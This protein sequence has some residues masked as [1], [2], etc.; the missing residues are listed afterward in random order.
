MNYTLKNN[1]KK[2]AGLII[3][4]GWGIGAKDDSDGVF[5]AKTPFFDNLINQY[6]NA[7]LTTFG[8]EVGLPDGQMG[9][10]EVGHLNI[11]A[12]RIVYQDLLRINNAIEDGSFFKNPQLLKAIRTAT[13]N[14]S[15]I[16]L[17]G[18]V[19]EGGV[20]SSLNHLLSLCS[21]L[22][23]NFSGRV[24]IHGFSDGRDCGPT[25]GIE[26][27]EKLHHHIHNS[28][29]VLS[30]IIG[31]YYAMDRDQRWERIKK[32]YDLLIEGTGEI[33][34]DYSTAF[35]ESYSKEITDEFLEPVKIKDNNGT[36]LDNDLVVCFNFRTDRC[37]QIT[38]AL[39]QSNFSEHGMKIK[40]LHFYTMT[41]YDKTFK[42]IEVIYDKD[43]LPMTLGEVLSNNNKK[44]L[45]IAETEKYPHVTYFFSGGREQVF[46]GESR[47]VVSS[48][49]VATYDLQPE[50]SAEKVASSTV[51]FLEEKRPDFLC[52]NFANPDMV[53]HTGVQN[54][55]I[56]ACETVDNCLKKVVN[57]LMEL[58]YSVIIIADHGNADK[59][60]NKDGSPHTA[61][62][63]NM[64]PV[65][66]LDQN[67]KVVQNGKL[68]D[69]APSILKLMEIEK[70]KEMSGESII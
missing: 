61:H 38:T 13:N 51:D 7:H 24:Y 54:A 19:S 45:R 64:V 48:P 1:M 27:F 35:K 67:V 39:T 5:L 50:M 25:T 18:L 14:K 11:G 3:L 62:T 47:I 43:N 44:Q 15:A 66:V 34:E 20:H 40:P 58:D 9:N 63:L 21:F 60:K 59:L 17:M 26:S 37:R 42:N 4:D 12:G 31:R 68:A 49:K 10:S 52:L 65:I 55:I 36:I 22:K 53:G 29:I 8:K 41:N 23:E 69:I 70:P 28:N 16:H 30:S 32:A 46:D 33:K 56:K 2:K 57:S 6:P